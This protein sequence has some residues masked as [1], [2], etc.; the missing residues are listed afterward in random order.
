VDDAILKQFH[1]E[2]LG[3]IRQ[4]RRALSLKSRALL[5][6]EETA[7]YLGIA[8]KTL[9]NRIGPR[10]PRPFPVRPCRVGG[11]VFFKRAALER[12]VEGLDSET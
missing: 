1:D 10:A 12:F 3:E 11:R 9:R 2:I 5:S 4:L 6:V 7:E 8:A